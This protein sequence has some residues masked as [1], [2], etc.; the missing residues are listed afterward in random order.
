MVGR[1][2][3]KPKDAIFQNICY[4][5]FIKRFQLQAKP[6]E[7][8][9]Q[10]EEFIDF[11]AVHSTVN[12]YP[13]VLILSSSE[14]LHY[15]KVELVLQD[16]VTNKFKNPKGYAKYLLFMFYPFHYECEL[17]LGQ[18][19]KLSKPWVLQIMNNNSF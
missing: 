13:D 1:Y 14:K 10:Q 11:E 19:P 7:N 17:K 15:G 6:I 3:I 18:S 5:L 16:Q 4:E 9:S 8:Y 2:L 12:L